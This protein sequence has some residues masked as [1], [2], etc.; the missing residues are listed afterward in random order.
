MKT[1]CFKY[2]FATAVTASSIVNVTAQTGSSNIPVSPANAPALSNYPF[3][4]NFSSTL[5]NNYVREWIPDEPTSTQNLNIKYRQKTTYLD[6]LG[7]PLQIV[8]LKGHADGYDIVE[9]HIYDNVGRESV[10]FLPFTAQATSS[11][12]DIQYN[13]KMRIEQFYPPA[14]GQLPYSLTEF[15]NSPL[16]RPVKTMAPGKNW[17][18]SNRGTTMKYDINIE[19]YLLNGTIPTY[20]T[21]KG[22]YPKFSVNSNNVL[23]NDGYYEEGELYITRVIDEDGMQGEEIKDKSGKVIVKRQLSN[24]ISSPLPKELSPNNYTYTINVYD[25][26]GRLRYVLPP[27]ATTPQLTVQSNT[28]NNITYTTHTYSWTLPTSAQ[29]EGLC[30]SYLYDGRGRLIERKIPGKAVDFMVYDERDRLVLSQ[31][32]NLRSQNKWLM[33][34]HDAQNRPV[35]TALV[36]SSDNRTTMAGYVGSSGTYSAPDWRYYASQNDL[37]HNYPSSINNTYILSYTYYDNYDELS[38]MQFDGNKTPTMPA[39][40]DGSIVPSEMCPAVKGLVTGTKLR[41]LNPDDPNGNQWITTVQY[42]DPKGRPIQSAQTNL[43]GGTDRTGSLYYFQGMAYRNAV[44]HQNPAATALPG[45]NSA[46]N[47]IKVEKTFKRNL[48]A[49]GN[50]LVWSIQQRINDGTPFDLA[51]YDYNHL[52]QPVIKQFT[53]TDVLQEYN[54]R[55]WVNHIQARKSTNHDVNFFNETIHY[56]D[57][58]ANK[59]YNGNIAGITWKY[60][61][62]LGS[63][64]NNA[65]GYTYDKLS[66]LNHA[67][68][69]ELSQ[70]GTWSNAHK[71]YTASAITYDDRGN[72]LTMNQRGNITNPVNMDQLQYTYASTSNQLVKVKDNIAATTTSSLPDFKDGADLGIEYSYDDNG[73]LVSDANKDIGSITYNYLNKPEKI[74][75]IG[76]GEI[77]YV[78]DAGGN[79]LQKKV[80]DDIANTTVIWDYIGGFVYKD[81]IL[82]YITNEEGRCRP[83]VVSS[84]QQNGST[85]FVYDYFIKDHL[86]NIRSTIT[87][88]PINQQYLALHEI[89]TANSEQLI[90]DNIA[91]VRD[92]KPGSINPG[93][94]KAAHLIASDPHKRIGTAIMLRVMPGDHF[95]FGADSYYESDGTEASETPTAEEI[96]N[97]LLSTLSGGTVGGV[98]VSEAGENGS[99]INE[100][101]GSSDVLN[102]MQDQLNTQQNAVGPKAGLNYL[103]FDQNLKL[104][105][106]MSG[107]LSVN[108]G[109]GQFSNMSVSPTPMTEPGYVVVFVDNNSIGTDV[110][111]DNVQISHFKGQVLEENH[112]Y[113]F[114]LTISPSDI[115]NM[116]EQPFKYNGKELEKSFGLETYEYGARQYDPQIGRWKGLDPLA[117]K[118]LPISPF[119]YVANNPIQF[120]DPDGKFIFKYTDADLKRFGLTRQDMVRFETVV[121]NAYKVLENNP[122]AMLALMNSTGLTR[123]QILNDFK[124]N[125]GPGILIE[126]VR[127]ALAGAN[128]IMFNPVLIKHL[129]S[130][131]ASNKPYLASQALGMVLTVIHEYTHDGDRRTNNGF[132]SG[133]YIHGADV[134]ENGKTNLVPKWDADRGYPDAVKH[135]K[136]FWTVSLTGHRGTDVELKGFGQAVQADVKTGEFTPNKD[137]KISIHTDQSRE[138]ITIPSELPE[139]M[140]GTTILE[141]LNLP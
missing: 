81:N 79:R 32:G 89:V 83:L 90:F 75:V 133:Q 13:A 118:Y 21:V 124:P 101:L 136:Q 93:D 140:Q 38:S 115:S 52:G 66:R 87:A 16:N 51:Y 54:I 77:T 139:N 19:K 36:N 57:G 55:G 110:W 84:G 72:I 50:D 76:K 28:I 123:E 69:R 108:L 111:F 98:P 26:F 141:T 63:G 12:G 40:G 131:D 125:Q 126:N 119:A 71:D 49:G 94:L 103:Y 117:D 135:G 37:Y 24:I 88:E 99:I 113:P 74:K 67:E 106:W 82:Q 17:V 47:N 61:D 122:Q 31:D 35:M 56:D 91:L 121:N 129:A 41:V 102:F 65:Y 30:F 86:G 45:A 11:F 95:T 116:P 14:D 138:P 114:G 6:G 34:I 46:L 85:K 1:N 5:K 127:G 33:T 96:V 120:I 73:N 62:S 107:K 48:A 80:K 128:G 134:D 3:V 27:G 130:I 8:H 23:Q 10:Q 100:A 9:H 20:Y 64:G 92:D 39:L 105:P 132:Y 2:I 7:R 58:F 53:T 42:Y 22:S 25:D 29:L 70:G 18:G 78:Y 43:K 97:S 59:L 15:D 137:A 60:Y 4:V 109:A 104:I 112:Y 44:W 68:Y